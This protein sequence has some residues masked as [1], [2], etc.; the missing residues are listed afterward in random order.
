MMVLP[1]SVGTFF[2]S[3]SETSLKDCAVDKISSISSLAR[4]SIVNISF[5]LSLIQS[6]QSHHPRHLSL[7]SAPLPF[8]V[9]RWAHSC[10]HNPVLWEV[11]C[12]PCLSGRQTGYWQ[13]F[14]SPLSHSSQP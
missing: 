1:R 12:V 14:R 6:P 8:P 13:A 3:L 2:I 4:S 7:S 5:L 10:R 11:P 9:L